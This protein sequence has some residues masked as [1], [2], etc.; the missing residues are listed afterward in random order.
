MN[1][2]DWTYSNLLSPLQSLY[3][4][5]ERIFAPL[6]FLAGVGYDTATLTRIDRLFDNLIFMTYLLLLGLLIVLLG[7][8]KYRNVEESW[9]ARW[10]KYFPY[11]LQFLLGGL[12]SAYAIYYFR[13]VSLSSTVYF[14]LILVG[15]LIANELLVDRLM[16]LPFLIVL[17]LF[18]C[19]SYF[20]YLFP[21]LVGRMGPDLFYGGLGTSLAVVGLVLAGIFHGV[22]QEHGRSLGLIVTTVLLVLGI[23]VVSYRRNWIPPVPLSMEFG[24]VYHNVERVGDQFHLT[25]VEPPWYRLQ[26][27][28][29]NPFHWQKGDLVHSFVSVFA[30]TQL[31]TNVVQE[32]Q[33]WKKEAG[34]T[35]TDTIEYPIIG[36]RGGGYRGN[37]YKRNVWPGEWRIN[38]K[39]AGGRLLGR[40]PFEIILSRQENLPLVKITK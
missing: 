18:V 10:R 13:S 26:Q 14:F 37:S 35:T 29:E 39:T 11:L 15:L 8:L 33:V 32:W 25:Y 28:Y 6:F 16:N 12:F 38:V 2:W 17:Y 1:I 23:F 21:I 24:G 34:W 9:Y 22:W 5:H 36:G 3:Q 20:I 31:R 4:E 30:P 40:I 27:S 7:R 19:S